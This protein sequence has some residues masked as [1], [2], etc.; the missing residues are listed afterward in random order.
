MRKPDKQLNNMRLNG[1]V[2]ELSHTNTQDTGAKMQI[3]SAFRKWQNVDFHWINAGGGAFPLAGASKKRGRAPEN[4]VI[5]PRLYPHN[6]PGIS[7][8]PHSHPR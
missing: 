4:V 5:T 2:L 8:Y 3:D 1:I 6:D 7:L